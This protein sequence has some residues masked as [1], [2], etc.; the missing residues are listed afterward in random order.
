V[1]PLNSVNYYN[2][3]VNRMGAATAS[4]A[5]R[6]FM[7]PGMNHCAG[8]EGPNTFDRMGVIENWVEKGQAPESIPASHSTNGRVDRTRPLCPFP[9]V[10]R[11]RGTG[12]IDDAAS[13]VCRAPDTPRRP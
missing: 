9:Q 11:Y 1:A 10:A 3:I 7:M 6:L 13:F 5:V 4:R 8:G 12:S 2:A